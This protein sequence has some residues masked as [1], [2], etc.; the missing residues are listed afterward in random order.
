MHNAEKHRDAVCTVLVR[1]ENGPFAEHDPDTVC[2]KFELVR[3]TEPLALASRSTYTTD[4]SH[5]ITKNMKSKRARILIALGILFASAGNTL[6]ANHGEPD[7]PIS[8]VEADIYVN[9]TRI[10]MRLTCF[11]EDLEMLQGVEALEDGLYDSEELLDATQD[12]AKYLAEKIT[13][14]DSIGE[15][16]TPKITEIIDIEIPDEGIKAGNLMNYTMGFVLEFRYKQPPEFITVQQDMVADGALLPSELKIMLKQAGSDTPYMHMMKPAMPETFRFDWDKPILLKGATDEEIEE[17]FEEQR[18]KNLGIT[19]YSSVYSFIYITAHEVRH[20]VLIPLATLATLMEFDRADKSFLEIDEQE[21]AAGRIKKYFSIGNPVT[22]DSIEVQPV[23]DRVD[24]YG[25]DLRDFAVRAEKRKV[26]MASG[27]VGIIMSYS[28]KGPPTSV[29]VVWDKFNNAIKSVDS[30][31]IAYDK[32]EKTQFSMFLE[33]NTFEWS[34]PDRKPLPPITGVSST[35]DVEALK[36]RVWNLP[37]VSVGL[38][39]IALFSLVVSLLLKLEWKTS[40]AFAAVCGIASVFTTGLLPT[41]VPDPF[42][43]KP[44]FELPE[45]DA[46]Q[47]FAQLHKNLFRA[48]DYHKESDVYDALAKSVDGELLRQMYLDITE[49]LRVKEQGGAIARVNEVQFVE[50]KKKNASIS[51]FDSTPQFRYR[52]KWNLIGTI[53]HWGHI[54]ERENKYAATFRVQLRDDAWKITSMY[55][56]NEEQGVVKTSLRKF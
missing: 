27:R 30:V 54:H 56:V 53:E 50:G 33:D 25:L 3:E 20:E 45:D 49:S 37:L 16:M 40:L 38:I 9:R 15:L 6:A 46:Q 17:W 21:A 43:E 7:H 29:E 22:I 35:I 39:G 8:V 19:S 51:P 34:E 55:D 42:A 28:T 31:V 41:E 4:G 44:V 12:H 32:I 18:E 5:L 26:S 52:C 23:F 13:I 2:F 48:F 1:P 36:P 24:F 10:T 11:A 47:V 14:R